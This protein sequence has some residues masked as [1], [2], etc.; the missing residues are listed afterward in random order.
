MARAIILP[1][2]FHLA[3]RGAPG[4]RAIRLG[5]GLRHDER[6]AG[7]NLPRG[8]RMGR[9]RNGKTNRNKTRDTGTDDPQT[10]CHDCLAGWLARSRGVAA[11][12][13]AAITPA[14]PHLVPNG[15]PT[16][17]STGSLAEISA[18]FCRE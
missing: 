7:G 11:P 10:V 13:T 14:T 6:A 2:L 15:R 12:L 4:L 3:L 5:R 8:M 1:G 17:S 18:R 9:D 16:V